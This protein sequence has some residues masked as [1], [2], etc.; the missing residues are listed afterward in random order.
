[1]VTTTSP[2]LQALSRLGTPTS[3]GTSPFD[4]V[5]VRASVYPCNGRCLRCSERPV[6]PNPRNTEFSPDAYVPKFDASIGYTAYFNR[7]TLN[8]HF[9]VWVVPSHP[10]SCIPRITLTTAKPSGSLNPIAPT[11]GRTRYILASHNNPRSGCTRHY[12][13]KHAH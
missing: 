11:I 10:H 3:I 2:S 7:W 9:E 6:H 4:I 8:L 13:E 12:R 5:W 1:M